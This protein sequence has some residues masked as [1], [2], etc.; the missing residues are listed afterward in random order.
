MAGAWRVE[1]APIRWKMRMHCKNARSVVR[2]PLY[3]PRTSDLL[4]G[5]WQ[6]LFEPNKGTRQAPFE[7]ACYTDVKERSK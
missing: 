4:R 3:R 2:G 5:G 6:P 7:K 1:S